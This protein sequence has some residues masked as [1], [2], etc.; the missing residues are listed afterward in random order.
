MSKS[1]PDGLERNYVITISQNDITFDYLPDTLDT[2][3]LP[4]GA[5]RYRTVS[6]SGLNLDPGYWH[7]IAVTVYDEDS[8]FY[9]N[10][11]VVLVEPLE[12]RMV[13]DSTSG[14]VFLGQ[15]FECEREQQLIMGG[16]GG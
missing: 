15:I 14:T 11:T 6:V 7:H 8:A 13:D 12:G 16:G 2:A 9:V 4:A 5:Q 1:S 10:G 3:S